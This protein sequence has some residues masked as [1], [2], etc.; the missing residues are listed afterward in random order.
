MIL[1]KLDKMKLQ[2]YSDETFSQTS[3]EAFTVLINPESYT[4]RYSVEHS[5]SQGQ[6]TSAPQIHFNRIAAQE[7]HFDFVFDSS[8]VVVE[9]SLL[10]GGLI[11]PF[12]KTANVI[13]QIETFKTLMLTYQSET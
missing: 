5:K 9:P 6:G 13:D 7:I 1:G 10:Q 12:A 3:G 2:A 8:G 11:N 4:V